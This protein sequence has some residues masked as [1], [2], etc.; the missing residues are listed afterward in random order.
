MPSREPDFPTRKV[1][2]KL[3]SGNQ[4]QCQVNPDAATF[5]ELRSIVGNALDRAL[6]QA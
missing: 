5:A 3:D 2:T 1:A 6:R 4:E